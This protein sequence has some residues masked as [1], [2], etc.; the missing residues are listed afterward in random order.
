M[1][2]HFSL[3]LSFFA[4]L[5]FLFQ[6][7]MSSVLGQTD[8]AA[9]VHLNGLYWTTVNYTGVTFSNGDDILVVNSAEEWKEACAIGKP[10]CAS[11]EFDSSN[12]DLFGL[13]YNGFAIADPRGLGTN[14]Y[15]LPSREQFDDLQK[16][17]VKGKMEV[18]SETAWQH[19]SDLYVPCGLDA[20][21]TGLLD[22]QGAFSEVGLN[23]YLWTATPYK[24]NNN[25]AYTIYPSSRKYYLY[26]FARNMGF[27]V[28]LV[29]E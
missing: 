29:K 6:G 8:S 13:F 12:E 14:G 18:Y 3:R 22:E 10:V 2:N 7:P 27:P 17:I 20:L 15:C 19:V 4:F 28:R 24:E 11:Y 5:L 16:F 21:P 1:K 23:G 26:H 25:Y 9:E